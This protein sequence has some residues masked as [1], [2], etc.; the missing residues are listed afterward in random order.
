MAVHTHRPPLKE[1][2]RQQTMARILDAAVR[3]YTE[4]GFDA[5]T[6]DDIA[7]AAECSRSTLFRYFGTKED[8]L[9]GDVYDQLAQ[10]RAELAMLP[11]VDDPWQAAKDVGLS[12]LV[13]SFHGETAPPPEAVALWFTHPALLRTY[14]HINHQWEQVMAEFFAAQRGTDPRTDLTSQLEASVAV[15]AVRAALMAYSIPGTDVQAAIDQAFTTVE[16]GIR[17]LP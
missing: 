14:L 9:F 16:R 17:P 13:E 11:K 12:R 7:D 15:S 2:K 10:V 8:I 4:R 6:A 1:R 3:L 5:T